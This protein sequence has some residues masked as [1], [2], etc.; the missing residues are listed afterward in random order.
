MIEVAPCLEHWAWL[1]SDS[2]PGHLSA[3]APIEQTSSRLISARL[4][5]VEEFAERV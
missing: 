3:Q 5:A 4:V 2:M 1:L